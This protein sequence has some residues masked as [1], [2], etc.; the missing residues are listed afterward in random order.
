MSF[1]SQGSMRWEDFFDPKSEEQRELR[2]TVTY[3]V[4]G[5]YVISGLIVVT[6]AYMDLTLGYYFGL[7][8]IAYATLIIGVNYMKARRR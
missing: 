8:V 6:M 1:Y 7:L 3:M 4:I 2:K 5:F